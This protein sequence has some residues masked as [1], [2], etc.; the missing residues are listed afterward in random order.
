MCNLFRYIATFWTYVTHSLKTGNIN[1][2]A[3]VKIPIPI[4]VLLKWGGC[5]QTV[6]FDQEIKHNPT[7]KIYKKI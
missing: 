1:E 7:Q 5:F 6:Y 3:Q 4:N 2:V